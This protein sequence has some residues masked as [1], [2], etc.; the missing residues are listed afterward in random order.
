MKPIIIFLL[1]VLV[2]PLVAQDK[3]LPYAELPAYPETFTAGTAA[4]RMIDGLGFR[5]FWATGGL[6]P[7]DLSYKPSHRLTPKKNPSRICPWGFFCRVSNLTCDPA[8]G[9]I[10][11]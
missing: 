1:M 10:F 3:S 8:R 2:S 6:P 5:F 7:I 4:S 9:G 11:Y